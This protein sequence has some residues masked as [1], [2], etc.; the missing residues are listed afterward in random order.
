[1]QKH[2][3]Y[4]CDST[5]HAQYLKNLD[6]S[7]QCSC[8]MNGGCTL[9]EIEEINVCLGATVSNDGQCECAITPITTTDPVTD[10]VTDPGMS[11]RFSG[12]T[13][14]VENWTNRP[15]LPAYFS[16]EPGKT[17]AFQP[18]PPEKFPV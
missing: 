5:F 8:D 11:T 17:G 7:I 9:G 6:G 2:L 18:E 16:V 3:V 13:G 4:E 15:E 14:T 1:M 10:P 12:S